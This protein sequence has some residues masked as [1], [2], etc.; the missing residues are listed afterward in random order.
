MFLFFPSGCPQGIAKRG[1]YGSFLQDEW[2]LIYQL[3]TSDWHPPSFLFLRYLLPVNTLHTNLSIPVTAKFRIFPE[4][5]KTIAYAQMM[6]RAGASILTCHGRTR[7]M[8]GQITVS[9]GKFG[10]RSG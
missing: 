4:V 10:S 5:E 3:S 2:D 9:N 8:K 6:E 1:K 7:E